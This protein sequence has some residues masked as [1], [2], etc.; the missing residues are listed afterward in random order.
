MRE[1]E[2]VVLEEERGVSRERD[3][4]KTSNADSHLKFF[5]RLFCLRMAATPSEKATPT[6]VRHTTVA[7]TEP[8]MIADTESLLVMTVSFSGI[9][10]F[11]KSPPPL[12]VLL[13]SL[14]FPLVVGPSSVSMYSGDV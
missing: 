3:A 8:A 14:P 4:G 1:R 12:I 7:T 2:R 9:V 11:S 5:L 6:S 10:A 13:V